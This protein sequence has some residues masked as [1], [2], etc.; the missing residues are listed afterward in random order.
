MGTLPVRM[1]AASYLAVAIAGVLFLA[2]LSVIFEASY[3]LPIDVRL[4]EFLG[5]G[6]YLNRLFS[7]LFELI[8]AL[9]VVGALGSIAY[10]RFSLKLKSLAQA[11]L[12]TGFSIDFARKLARLYK[13]LV[14]GSAAFGI[15]G[16]GLISIGIAY[17]DLHA[18]QLGGF[19]ALVL[20]VFAAIAY[21]TMRFVRTTPGRR[22]KMMG[23]AAS[24]ILVSLATILACGFGAGLARRVAVS[25]DMAI[26]TSDGRTIDAVFVERFSSGVAYREA[27]ATGTR[28]VPAGQ[29]VAIEFF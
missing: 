16:L 25:S 2:L 24:V 8:V 5:V 7:L 26:H 19:I 21:A 12:S 11:F 14:I 13:C 18:L 4:L 23:A 29:I 10:W 22:R 20:A 1:G 27:G 9:A 17:S 3:L 15:T 6:D 28:F